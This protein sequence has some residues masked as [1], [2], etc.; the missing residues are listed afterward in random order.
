MIAE[1]ERNK[2]N[3]LADLTELEVFLRAKIEEAI[4]ETNTYPFYQTYNPIVA[5][6]NELCY[7]HPFT[8]PPDVFSYTVSAKTEC[9]KDCLSIS[10]SSC[11][12]ELSSLNREET[13]GY[14]AQQIAELHTRCEQLQSEL[15]TLQGSHSPA[16]P[17]DSSPVFNPSHGRFSHFPHGNFLQ[18]LNGSISQPQSPQAGRLPHL[19]HNF[20]PPSALRQYASDP[21]LDVIP[22]D[23]IG[24]S[25]YGPGVGRPQES[26]SN[27]SQWANRRQQGLAEA[28]EPGEAI[29]G[30]RPHGNRPCTARR[31]RVPQQGGSSLLPS[32]PRP[33]FNAPGGGRPEGGEEV[34]RM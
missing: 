3:L 2:T 21:E 26:S 6:I 27:A 11:I 13:G 8:L 15:S 31:L 18:N 10:F 34:L 22:D 9:L 16:S 19:V 7:Q 25:Y 1:L 14:L 20:Q 24:R 17:T 30:G 33:A 32:L 12:P 28:L 23:G 29:Y 4:L 5:S